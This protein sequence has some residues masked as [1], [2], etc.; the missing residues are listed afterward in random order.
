[1]QKL[2][3]TL[4]VGFYGVVETID[5]AVRNLQ[6]RGFFLSA[7]HADQRELVVAGKEGV[8]FTLSQVDTG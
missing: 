4:D 6:L 2:L 7:R 5:N 1:M 3:P 8:V